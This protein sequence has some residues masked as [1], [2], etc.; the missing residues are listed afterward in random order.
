MSA[1]NDLPS[2]IDMMLRYQFAFS[3]G[4]R[5]CIGINLAMAEMMLMLTGIFRN[6]ESSSGLKLQ[7][8]LAHVELFDTTVRDVETV[9][10]GGVPLQHPD[11]KGIR[12]MLS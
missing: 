11:S 6:C 10:D 3:K 7:D 12:V 9:G 4:T 2:N 8:C 1:S 5:N